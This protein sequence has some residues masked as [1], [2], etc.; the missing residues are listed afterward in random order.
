MAIA[1]KDLLALR[2]LRRD[3]QDNAGLD[4]PQATHTEV[5][6]LYDVCKSLDLN[7]FQCKEILGE[8]GWHYIND[9]L[10]TPVKLY[11]RE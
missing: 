1:V 9:Y 7:I 4:F 8:I 5:L 6:V 3:I 10:E 11:E 2:Q